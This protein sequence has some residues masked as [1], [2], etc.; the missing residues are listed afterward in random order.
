MSFV[1]DKLASPLNKRFKICCKT[2]FE[3]I[4]VQKTISEVLE[5]WYFVC[6][7]FF[8]RQADGGAIALPPWLCYWPR[9]RPLANTH[10]LTYAVCLTKSRKDWMPVLAYFC[11]VVL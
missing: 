10:V 8:V 6:S 11:I 1:F 2:F 3:S 9:Y 7:A 4:P 5:T